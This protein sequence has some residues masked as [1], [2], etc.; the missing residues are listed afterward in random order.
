MADRKRYDP[1]QHAPCSFCGGFAAGEGGGTGGHPLEIRRKIAKDGGGE[2]FMA[3][4][5]VC[6]ECA[7]LEPDERRETLMNLI[8]DAESCA[9]QSKKF[10]RLRPEYGH[11]ERGPYGNRWVIDGP[12]RAAVTSAKH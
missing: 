7:A 3:G 1:T 5:L 6:G 8:V 4:F 12:P 11:F 10:A 2:I 9:Q